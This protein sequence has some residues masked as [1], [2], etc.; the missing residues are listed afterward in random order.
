MAD[1]YFSK[2]LI[3]EHVKDLLYKFEVFEDDWCMKEMT[4][5]NG[6]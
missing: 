1:E 3:T 6:F 2:G 4:G 5:N